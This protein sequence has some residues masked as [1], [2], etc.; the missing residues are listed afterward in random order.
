MA[1]PFV[2][3]K[4]DRTEAAA[5]G[6]AFGRGLLKLRDFL[7][8]LQ[9]NAKK[10][11]AAVC[12]QDIHLLC[13]SMGN[14]VLQNTLPRVD[15]FTPGTALPRLFEHIFLC[16]PDVDDNVLE[17]GQPMGNLHE[18]ARSISVYH[19]RGDVAMYVSD[20]T[21]GNPERLGTSGAARPASLHNKVHQI[22]CTPIVK[23]IVEHSYYM[24]GRVNQDIRFSIG[25]IAHEDPRRPRRRSVDLPN[26]W[27]M[28]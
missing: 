24:D 27:E 8:S 20:Y 1:L 2:S 22:D 3:Y 7:R 6:Y 23:G 28:R 19:N 13:H 15:Q 10:G 14:F 4:S 11:K 17:S 9:A 26:V 5:S 18:L 21:K 12:E 25:G 16:A